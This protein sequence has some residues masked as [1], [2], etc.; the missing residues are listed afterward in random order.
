MILSKNKT[1]TVLE[2]NWGEK[3]GKHFK[4]HSQKAILDLREQFPF[5]SST[6]RMGSLVQDK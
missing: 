2:I 4:Y 3:S 6:Q 1:E 5:L